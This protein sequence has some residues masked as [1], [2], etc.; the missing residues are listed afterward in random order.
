MWTSLLA[1]QLA[2]ELVDYKQERASL[3]S[4]LISGGPFE[5]NSDKIHQKTRL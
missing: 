1:N 5:N 4:T 2:L 3:H